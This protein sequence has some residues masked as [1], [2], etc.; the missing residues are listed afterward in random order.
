MDATNK[1]YVHDHVSSY[2]N[3][4]EK[5]GSSNRFV[6]AHR[7]NEDRKAL[8]LDEITKRRGLVLSLVNECN[9]SLEENPSQKKTTVKTNDSKARGKVKAKSNSKE[10]APQPQ[11]TD[12]R[13]AMLLKWRE[14]RELKRKA[15]V[16]K[17]QE[18][19]V[20]A[21]R[22][23]KYDNK[24]ILAPFPNKGTKLTPKKPKP[25]S[26][27][28]AKRVTRSSAKLAISKQASRKV[29]SS[30]KKPVAVI[31]DEDVPKRVTRQ[32][33]KSKTSLAVNQ[34][35]DNEKNKLE[36]KSKK[37][38]D[39]PVE[40]EKKVMTPLAK[41][42]QQRK[43]FAPPNFQFTAPSG[44]C[45]FEHYSK[46]FKF[47]PLSPASTESFFQELVPAIPT[48]EN[49]R[50]LITKDN[51][52]LR[53]EEAE[54]QYPVLMSE[55]TEN[56][57]TGVIPSAD[58]KDVESRTEENNEQGSKAVEN[59][60]N[61]LS[62]K[63]FR[64]LVSSETEKLNLLCERWEKVMESD[65]CLPEEAKG[66]IR[67]A[68]GQAQLLISQ[69]FKQFSGL[70]NLSEDETAEKKATMSD[71]QGFWDM[72][73]FQ[74]EDVN[75][76][77]DSLEKQKEKN[78]I[79]ETKQAKTASKKI[80]K[81]ATAKGVGKRDAKPADKS[82]IQEMRAAMKA[83][84]A[85]KKRQMQA[86]DGESTSFITVLTPVKKSK[87]SGLA[88]EVVLTPVRRSLRNTPVSHSGAP[89]A[90][91]KVI[92]TPK[93]FGKK[94]PDLRLTPEA[95]VGTPCNT[96]SDQSSEEKMEKEQEI[97]NAEEMKVGSLSSDP[98]A[99]TSD[100]LSA[101]ENNIVENTDEDMEMDQNEVQ[102][103]TIKKRR[104]CLRSS[105]KK[106]RKSS[107]VFF[108]SP[109][110]SAN[111]TAGGTPGAIGFTPRVQENVRSTGI[112]LTPVAV[113]FDSPLVE[114]ST[115]S[116]NAG[117]TPAPYSAR[118]SSLRKRASNVTPVRR[119]TRSHPNTTPVEQDNSSSDS[120]PEMSTSPEETHVETPSCVDKEIAVRSGSKRRSLRRSCRKSAA[121]EQG[122]LF[123]PNKYFLP[124][125]SSEEEGDDT[126]P[127][128]SPVLAGKV[129]LPNSQSLVTFTP[130][131]DSSNKLNQSSMTPSTMF[132][133]LS[134][135]DSENER[136]DSVFFAPSGS[137]IDNSQ[138]AKENL[139]CFSPVPE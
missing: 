16:A 95:V 87:K 43:S 75:T 4:G 24:T 104:S 66:N 97:M 22:H 83:K 84:M 133:A 100:Y 11:V 31:K 111:S 71:L 53:N 121:N 85:E 131:R 21:V 74:V 15:E 62:S 59:E 17:K 49:Q 118:R 76:K 13:K 99:Q 101:K 56:T 114:G 94:S 63:Y 35:T 108:Q 125:T 51:F 3:R 116:L 124:S 135:N 38:K 41:K 132:M 28:P 122:D 137:L 88:G 12:E 47:Q 86:E 39:P 130:V 90:M 79:V 107:R 23:I 102:R 109:Q 113:S 110:S 77:M 6:R 117:H 134:L 103:D 19:G 27:P 48:P 92:S 93:K 18:K 32:S 82:K 55:E 129:L 106:K 96:G 33:V 120:A 7:A 1:R 72:I 127:A 20:F 81:N 105:T 37:E 64:D 14:Q 73:Y 128:A 57:N 52:I 36:E 9:L 34:H 67:T 25:V 29:T 8:R 126:A 30:A 2:K 5:L 98:E 50:H 60:D 69:R 91:P 115:C 89:H 10:N 45:S 68:I 70:I 112:T 139:I 119:S 65:N 54:N 123:L 78:W 136:R 42:K 138:S 40:S 44:I 80:K 46:E 58:V 61:Q 26:V